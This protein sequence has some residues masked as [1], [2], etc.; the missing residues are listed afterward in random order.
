MQFLS[1]SCPTAWAQKV[2]DFLKLHQKEDEKAC[3]RAQ[4]RESKQQVFGSS[5][6]GV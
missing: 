5:Q 4:H 3:K 2:K 6:G 1:Q